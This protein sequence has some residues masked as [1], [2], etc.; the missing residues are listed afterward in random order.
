MLRGIPSEDTQKQV[1]QIY[2]RNSIQEK[3]ANR[4][5]LVVSGNNISI[6]ADSEESWESR[7]KQFLNNV[8]NM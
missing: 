4:L 8:K 3:I 6:S 7:L 1:I 5:S 2:S